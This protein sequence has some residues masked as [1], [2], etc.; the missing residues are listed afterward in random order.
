MHLKTFGEKK[1]AKF[2][3]IEDYYLTDEEAEAQGNVVTSLNTGTAGLVGVQTTQELSR[4]CIQ[5]KA[6]TPREVPCL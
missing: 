1:K 2:C 4:G 5:V 6:G 3:L